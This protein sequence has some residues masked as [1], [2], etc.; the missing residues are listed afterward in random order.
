MSASGIVRMT[1]SIYANI[2]QFFISKVNISLNI[3]LH[4]TE[5]FRYSEFDVKQ[6]CLLFQ[7]GTLHCEETI[8][9]PYLLKPK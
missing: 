5:R 8:S 2:S 9:P 4:G 1:M 7:L 3:Y 6:I